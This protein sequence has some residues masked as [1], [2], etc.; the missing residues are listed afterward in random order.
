MINYGAL[1][2][3]LG[4][5][6]KRWI[7]SDLNCASRKLLNSHKYNM[8]WVGSGQWALRTAFINYSEDPRQKCGA[9]KV[10]MDDRLIFSQAFNGGCSVRACNCAGRFNNSSSTN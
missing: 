9:K 7:N 8:S 6:Q 1:N 2:F 5:S 3:R 4:R 10:R